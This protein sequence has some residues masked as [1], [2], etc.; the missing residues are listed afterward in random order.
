[1]AVFQ[2]CGLWT[3]QKWNFIQMCHRMSGLCITTT[4]DINIY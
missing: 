3:K 4:S 1:M 2:T